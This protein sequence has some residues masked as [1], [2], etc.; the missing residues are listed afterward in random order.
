MNESGE[1]EK[2][3]GEIVTMRQNWKRHWIT[4]AKPYR[5]KEMRRN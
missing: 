3:K 4:D 5:Y 1:G 2:R